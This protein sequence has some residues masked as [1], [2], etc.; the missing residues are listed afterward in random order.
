MSTLQLL[1]PEREHR[2]LINQ[3]SRDKRHQFKESQANARHQYHSPARGYMAD[4]R[5][6]FYTS[7]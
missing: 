6:Y 1:L 4:C 2:S 7:H 3:M 5:K